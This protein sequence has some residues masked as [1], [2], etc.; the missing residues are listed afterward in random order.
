MISSKMKNK[1]MDFESNQ[2]PK[3]KVKREKGKVL[4]PIKNKKILV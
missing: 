2:N 3:A 1:K 4:T